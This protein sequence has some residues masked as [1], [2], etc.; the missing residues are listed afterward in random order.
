MIFENLMRGR[1]DMKYL[2]EAFD[3]KPLI[4]MKNTNYVLNPL[5]D[6][7]PETS[8]ELMRDVVQELSKITDFSQ[9]DKIVGEEDRGGYIA[10]LIAYEHKKSLGMVKWNPDIL[11]GKVGVDFRNAYTEGKMYLYGVNP[12]DKVILIEDMVDSGGTIISMIKLLEKIEVDIKDIVVLAEKEEYHGIERIKKETGR[13]VKCIL[14]FTCLGERSRV[15][16]II[17]NSK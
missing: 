12:G 17:N 6:H 16:R 1:V 5:L 3:D 8:F 11:K 7:E 13:D 14:Q 10:A 15:T 2:V 9:A 4:K